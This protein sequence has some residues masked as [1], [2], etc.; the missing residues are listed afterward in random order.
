MIPILLETVLTAEYHIG[1]EIRELKS[2]VCFITKSSEDQ[3][4]FHEY[5]FFFLAYNLYE[6]IL[7]DNF[8]P[9]STEHPKKIEKFSQWHGEIFPSCLVLYKEQY[10]EYLLNFSV[11]C[12]VLE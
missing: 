6:Y 8:G 4:S 9:S 11:F 3:T 7:T 1:L 2:Q 5:I 10:L 12:Q